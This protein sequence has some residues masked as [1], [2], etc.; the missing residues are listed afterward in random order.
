MPAP[1]ALDCGCARNPAYFADERLRRGELCRVDRDVRLHLVEGDRVLPVGPGDDDLERHLHAG[2]VT[3]IGVVDLRRHRADR[4]P[5]PAH[6][7][8]EEARVIEVEVHGLA[9]GSALQDL[10]RLVVDRRASDLPAGERVLDR[11]RE[12][13][14]ALRYARLRG[15]PRSVPSAGAGA[16]PSATHALRP[17]YVLMLSASGARTICIRWFGA[18]ASISIGRVR[19]AGV[20]A[21]IRP[22]RDKTRETPATFCAP[23]SAWMLG[24]NLVGASRCERGRAPAHSDRRRRRR[25]A[26]RGSGCLQGS[27]F[28]GGR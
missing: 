7:A 12:R 5:V 28:R 14:S 24:E 22:A 6:A 19:A 11:R 20:E 10:H 8:H 3:V 26:A 17:S 9:A 18:F 16:S 15:F 2:D 1:R 27:G 4:R 21:A 13:A 25:T 23:P